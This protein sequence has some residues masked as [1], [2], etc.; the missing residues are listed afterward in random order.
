[1]SGVI[2]RQVIVTWQD[3]KE[4]LP[5]EGIFVVVTFSGRDQNITYDHT[6]GIAEWYEGEGWIIQGLPEK[7]EFTIHA[8]ADLVPYGSKE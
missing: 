4:K 1:M 3:P 5:E 6:F 8:W 7:S 2:E